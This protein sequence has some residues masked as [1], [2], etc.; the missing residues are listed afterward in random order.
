M[1]E[2]E[3]EED[4]DAVVDRL[5]APAAFAGDVYD[6]KLLKFSRPWTTL[7]IIRKGRPQRR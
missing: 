1:L 6:V 5:T 7:R 3:E 4:G 2:E